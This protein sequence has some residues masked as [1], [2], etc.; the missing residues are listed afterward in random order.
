MDLKNCTFE[1]VSQALQ[2]KEDTWPE[3]SILRNFAVWIAIPCKMPAFSSFGRAIIIGSCAVERHF[4]ETCEN[5][6][7][8]G[9]PGVFL[10]APLT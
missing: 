4:R 9:A 6:Q 10:A 5:L 8:M 1:I 2:S 3:M 7:K